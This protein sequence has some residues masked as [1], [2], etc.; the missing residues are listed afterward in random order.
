MILYQSGTIIE[1]NYELTLPL[2]YIPGKDNLEIYLEG[3]RLINNI[4]YSEIDM[5]SLLPPEA[6]YKKSNK[7]QFI[8]STEDDNWTLTE[9][10]TITAVVRRSSTARND[11]NGRK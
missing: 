8:R 1:N 9:D 4:H 10:V 3:Q 7:I 6:L 2:Y 5:S 11:S